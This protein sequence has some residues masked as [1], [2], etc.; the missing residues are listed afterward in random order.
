MSRSSYLLFGIRQLFISRCLYH[1]S[2]ALRISSIQ[3]SLQLILWRKKR[4]YHI[5]LFCSEKGPFLESSRNYQARKLVL[6]TLKT[7]GSIVSQMIRKQNGLS[8][9]K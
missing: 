3:L 2:H 4:R 8:F 5:E 1:N 7:E 9:F 6:F